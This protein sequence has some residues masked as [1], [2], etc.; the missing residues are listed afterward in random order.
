VVADGILAVIA[1]VAALLGQVLKRLDGIDS[2]LDRLQ[3][4]NDLHA[5]R[6]KEPP[7]PP[8]KE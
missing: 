8:E 6:L 7:A 4:Q 5:E 2:K 3:I 1:E